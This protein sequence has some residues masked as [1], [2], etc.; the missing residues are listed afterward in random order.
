MRSIS[1][2]L[3]RIAS[4]IC[5]LIAT[6]CSG[7]G[8]S[9]ES[10]SGTLSFSVSVSTL[11][12]SINNSPVAADFTREF[13]VNS[14]INQN[15]NASVDVNWLSVLPASGNA[16]SETKVTTSLVQAQLDGML[17][18]TYIGTVTI[19]P[20][21]AMV[22]T[23]PVTL[24]ISQTQVNYAAPYVATSGD[25][26]KVIIRGENFD[27][28][29]VQNVMFGGTNATTFNVISDTEV[30]ATH[31]ALT[32]G[33]YT[34]QLQNNLG[35]NRSIANLVV[36]DAPAF[37]ETTLIY[38][39]IPP[40]GV[41]SSQVIDL[42]YDAERKTIFVARTFFPSGLLPNQ[43]HRYKH[44]TG[45]SA[46][47][48]ISIP[49]LIDLALS[50]DG[51]LW[52]AT[53]SSSITQYDA[54]NMNIGS[55]TD[56]TINSSNVLLQK[57]AIANDG[58]AVGIASNPPDCGNIIKYRI[59][60]PVISAL[61]N[62]NTCQAQ[63]GGSTDGSSIIA[64]TSISG[65]IYIFSASTGNLSPTGIPLTL[66]SSPVLNRSGSIIVLNN[67]RVYDANFILL[68]ELP[69]TTQAI[70]LNPDGSR[71][72]TYD[73]SEK[74][75]T[76]DLTST[77]VGGMFPEIGTGISP[78][79]NPGTGVQLIISPDGGTLFLAGKNMLVV[80]PAP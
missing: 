14:R 61:G 62:F 66:T 75:R 45:W 58:S 23:I 33:N 76:F 72:Y 63:A 1:P 73:S 15:W 71:A 12:Y 39:P 31:P 16:N 44:T 64:G 56:D 35:I 59:R 57:L 24:T 46:E 42:E 4:V 8:G 65:D 40:V 7:G 10:S 79:S 21:N 68:G 80:F 2:H 28:V 32:P 3:I 54:T 26:N 69:A 34:V 9:G 5:C 70:T 41:T 13:T 49:D 78:S 29:A 20:S 48:G 77:P 38:P 43:V 22:V 67:T 19:T 47:S 25:S 11:N 74:V 30:W 17:N 55:K 52:L 50:T 36:V 18:G 51:K 60:N 6:A 53:L 37:A 27:Q